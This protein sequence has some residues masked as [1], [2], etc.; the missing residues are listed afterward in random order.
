M[1]CS[2]WWIYFFEIH[3]ITSNSS[4][5]WIIYLIIKCTNNVHK[6]CTSSIYDVPIENKKK[7]RK[8]EWWWYIITENIL[9]YKKFIIIII[10]I[11]ILFS[12]KKNNNY[13]NVNRISETFCSILVTNMY[14]KC[15]YA[16]E[17]EKRIS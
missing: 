2:E 3:H 9:E 12:N 17:N 10:K 8:E 4:I 7:G 13:I 5:Y 11:Y 16:K 15:I 1:L 14:M 6:Q